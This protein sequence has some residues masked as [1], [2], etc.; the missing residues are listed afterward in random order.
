MQVATFLPGLGKKEQRRQATIYELAYSERAYYLHVSTLVQEFVVPIRARKQTLLPGCD[1]LDL[2][3]QYTQHL[4][5]VSKALC[6]DLDRR[7]KEMPLVHDISDIFEKHEHQI[8]V[9]LYHF[10]E[11]NTE[12]MTVCTDSAY[13]LLASNGAT[14][15]AQSCAVYLYLLH[16]HGS[17]QAKAVRMHGLLTNRFPYFAI[18]NRPSLSRRKKQPQVQ[19][20]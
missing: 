8:A 4:Q 2:F 9:A 6:D 15:T 20:G 18:S 16:P 14:P 13:P 19:T 7:Q 3:V 11:L 10:C 1:W 5:L 12:M 17:C